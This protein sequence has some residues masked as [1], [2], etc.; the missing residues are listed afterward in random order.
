[1]QVLSRWRLKKDKRW[2]KLKDKMAETAETEKDKI[3]ET[4]ET[5]KD[6]IADTAMRVHRDCKTTRQKHGLQRAVLREV[7][8][9]PVYRDKRHVQRR[10]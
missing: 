10:L 8:S 6:E 4:A 5:E 7:Y 1:M 3:T 9:K 2:Q